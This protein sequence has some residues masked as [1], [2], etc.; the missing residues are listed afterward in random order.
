MIDFET[1]RILLKAMR[2]E[3]KF[4]NK[5]CINCPLR[6]YCYFRKISPPADW[7]DRDIWE[8]MNAKRV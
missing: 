8:V 1:L 2:E 7:T 4:Q 6:C 3:C 5:F